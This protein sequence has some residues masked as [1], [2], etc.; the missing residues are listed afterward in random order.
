LYSFEL[1]LE[2]ERTA[3]ELSSNWTIVKKQ[4]RLLVHVLFCF[5]AI[6]QFCRNFLKFVSDVVSLQF[7]RDPLRRHY[8]ED[9]HW[10]KL[11]FKL[12]GARVPQFVLLHRTPLCPL[13]FTLFMMHVMIALKGSV[14]ITFS[15]NE[16]P[17]AYDNLV[18]ISDLNPDMNKKL[19]IGIASILENKLS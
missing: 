12:R 17:A 1:N 5:N 8:Q 11:I 15:G 16:Q 9:S 6:S 10:H 4:S 2:M 3:S 14:P 13:N 19:S 7:Y 18:S